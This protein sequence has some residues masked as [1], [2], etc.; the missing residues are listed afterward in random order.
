MRKEA[1]E[2][3][4][5]HPAFVQA[6]QL[7]L[8]DYADE[9]EFKAEY[10]LTT[11][12]LRIDVVVVKKK[13]GAVIDKNIGR[14]FRTHN[15]VEFKSPRDSFS[16]DDLFKTLAYV[17][18]YAVVE[19]VDPRNCTLTLAGARKP[20]KL[21]EYLRKTPGRRIEKSAEGMYY[22]YGEQFPIQII[23]TKRLPERENLWLAS[24]R[25]DLTAQGAEKV[26]AEG[27][28]RREA[29]IAA[30]LYALMTARPKTFREVW[31]MTKRQKEFEQFLTQVAEESGQLKKWRQEGI[32][33]GVHQTKLETARNFK[34][35]GVAVETISQ[36][37]G[38]APADI[39]AL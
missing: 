4:P 27:G 24:L 25:D 29:G 32:V 22:V 39:A 37:T 35:L 6:L 1:Q 10:R 2:K 19:G 5:W 26:L 13:P 31:N 7:E 28:K 36:A 15:I 11:E 20:A 23:E 3:I 38:L 16:T 33:Q 18:L 9:L 12:P 8:E 34:N 30:Y 21:M 17:F 14:L